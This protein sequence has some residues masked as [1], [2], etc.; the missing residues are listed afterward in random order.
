MKY[1]SRAQIASTIFA[2]RMA[3]FNFSPELNSGESQESVTRMV[4]LEVQKEIRRSWLLA[5]DFGK[6][7][8]E[9]QQQKQDQTDE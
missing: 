5:G 2:A 4:K 8:A 1:T 3:D 9:M 6:Q 7:V